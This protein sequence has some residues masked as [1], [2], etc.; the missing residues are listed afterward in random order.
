MPV[1]K[2]LSVLNIRFGFFKKFCTF[3]TLAEMKLKK[4]SRF[5]KIDKLNRLVMLAPAVE[6]VGEVIRVWGQRN[7][8]LEFI[9]RQILRKVTFSCYQGIESYFLF[10]LI[11]ISL[12]HNAVDLRYFK[13]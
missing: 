7:S 9:S 10:F 8:G 11:L 1:A 5:L 12:Q 2:L 13:L 6:I 3:L 4:L